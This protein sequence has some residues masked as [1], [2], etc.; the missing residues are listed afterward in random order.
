MQ[1]QMFML[2]RKLCY[3][4]NQVMLISMC[5]YIVHLENCIMLTDGTVTLYQSP[6]VLHNQSHIFVFVMY[7]HPSVG[8]FTGRVD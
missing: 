4:G 6:I 2:Q 3:H 8:Y 1:C 7:T 5:L